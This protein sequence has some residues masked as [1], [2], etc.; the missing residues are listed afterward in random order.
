MNCLEFRA[1][2]GPYVDGELS[3]A[4]I[5]AA[6]AHCA[7]C[8]DCARALDAEREFRALLRR[9]PR[10]PAPPELRAR[11]VAEVRRRSRRSVRAVRWLVP[12]GAL[13]AVL[14]AAALL[15][16]GRQSA[17]R[18]SNPCAPVSNPCA[19]G[20]AQRPPLLPGRQS[21][22]LVAALVEK[23]IGSAQLDR[24]AELASAD[25][26]EVAAWFRQRAA[27]RVIVPDYSASGI[28]LV[29]A[30]LAEAGERRAAHL[31]YEKGRTLLSVFMVPVSGRDVRLE[32]TRLSYR[33]GEYVTHEHKGYRTVA[34]TDG[35]T[36]FG[37]VSALDYDALLECADRL[38]AQHADRTRL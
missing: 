38:R 3:A 29:G 30:R 34:W 20:F 22:D 12:A 32:G 28:R 25:R 13:A 17:D 11:I 10:E 21:A 18:V 8:P 24:P 1:R 2:L 4:D 14:V 6:E 15:L 23:H 35:Y 33:G 26:D 9:Q 5:A 19:K 27:L 7:A 37:L 36:L 16:P 31:L